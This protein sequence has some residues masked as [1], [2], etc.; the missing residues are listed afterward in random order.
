MSDAEFDIFLLEKENLA[1]EAARLHGCVNCTDDL[2]F[3]V[4][5][6]GRQQVI[7]GLS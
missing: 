5:F 4:C 7:S 2:N 1:D 6:S 3:P